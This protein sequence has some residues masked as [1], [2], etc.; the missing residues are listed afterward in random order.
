MSTQTIPP[1]AQRLYSIFAKLPAAPMTEAEFDS[2]VKTALNR[3]VGAEVDVSAMRFLL[4]SSGAVTATTNGSGETVYTKAAA[5]P[6]HAPVEPGSAAFD[7]QNRELAQDEERQRDLDAEEA[8][9]NSP[10]N[11]QRAE[12]IALI[13][14][15]IDARL[16]AL[17]RKEIAQAEARGRLQG[18]VESRRT[19]G[20]AA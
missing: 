2:A 18:R 4:T 6:E 14:E 12:L 3:G 13:D 1:R 15:R 8:F 7:Q 17:K 10:Q 19:T 9:R 16:P 20:D 11:R 5:F